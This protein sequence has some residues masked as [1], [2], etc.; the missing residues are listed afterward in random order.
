MRSDDVVASEA[1]KTC[2]IVEVRPELQVVTDRYL[3]KR[4]F[5]RTA[6]IGAVAASRICATNCSTS[7]ARGSK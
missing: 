5:A 6:S 3:D 7:V 4:S 2:H 1:R